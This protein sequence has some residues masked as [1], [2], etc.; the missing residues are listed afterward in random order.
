[1]LTITSQ[2]LGYLIAASVAL[3][4]MSMSSDAAYKVWIKPSASNYP[5][6]LT[7]QVLFASGWV[8]P[9]VILLFLPFMPES[10][11]FLVMKGQREKAGRMLSR[12]GNRASE[13]PLIL[14]DIVRTHEEEQQRNEAAKEASFLECFKGVNWR[15]TRIILY[16]NALSQV[17]GSSFM[18][19]GPYFLV[20]A[21]MSS[22][23]TGMMTEIGIAFGIASS[24]VTGYVM[25]VCGRRALVM[26]G[27][28][29]STMLFTVMGIA[30]CFPHS[31]PALW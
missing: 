9:G 7:I 31:S 10:P 25:T 27:I 26:F 17:I 19:N 2:N 3:P 4:R 16:C 1:M 28:G 14:A 6:K 12:L 18:T 13:T 8:W 30:G 21:G 29:L 11:Y 5:Q 23:K 20:Q 22:A 15:R 24:L